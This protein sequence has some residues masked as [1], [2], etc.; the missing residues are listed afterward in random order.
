M[1]GG[2]DAFVNLNVQLLALEKRQAI[3][4]SR[5]IGSGR[6]YL[7]RDKAL[8]AEGENRMYCRSRVSEGKVRT[9]EPSFG[10]VD[11]VRACREPFYNDERSK[12]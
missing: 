2:G 11:S 5:R 8:S 4:G 1:K 7:L 12:R 10:F 3:R 6:L 9:L